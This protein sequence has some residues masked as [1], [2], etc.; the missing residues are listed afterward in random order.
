M[1][2]IIFSLVLLMTSCSG[3]VATPEVVPPATPDTEQRVTQQQ[4]M[5]IV[6]RLL[7]GW[8]RGGPRVVELLGEE[9]GSDLVPG[10]DTPSKSYPV[11]IHGG[12]ELDA[13]VSSL[14][15]PF[16]YRTLKLRV[17]GAGDETRVEVVRMS[18]LVSVHDIADAITSLQQH[19]DDPIVLPNVPTGGLHRFKLYLRGEGVEGGIDLNI[20]P[21]RRLSIQFG[22]AT[23]DGCGGD[24]AKVTRILGERALFS[25]IHHKGQVWS[26]LI[27]PVARGEI[28]GSYGLAGPFSLARLTKWAEQMERQRRQQV[29][30][31]DHPGC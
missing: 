13:V 9:P 12:W 30:A 22:I 6:D 24:S 27:W 17:L 14:H 21:E 15:K 23:F 19:I 25:T 29:R 5:S 18:E 20:A 8:D 10:Q 16:I 3:D 2:P 4:A 28:V 7:L 1:K 11:R 31:P 26:Q